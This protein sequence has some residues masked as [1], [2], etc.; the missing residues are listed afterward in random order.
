MFRKVSATLVALSLVLAACT[1][2]VVLQVTSYA[3]L[4]GATDVSVETVVTATFS[5]AIDEDTVEGSF[6]LTTVA[7]AIDGVLT[8]DAATRTAT[9]APDAPLAY[10]TLHTVT[11]SGSVATTGGVTLGGD[12]G[13]TFTTEAEPVE[14]A[15]GGVDVTPATADLLVGATV[16]LTATPSG[17]V[18]TPDLGVTWSSD[19]ETVATV[20]DAGLVTAQ[21]EGT[22][23]ITA[24]SDFDPSVSDSATIT[25]S[26]VPSVVSVSVT[27]T[28]PTVVVGGTVQLSADVVTVGGAADGVT[29]SSDDE[30]IAT[31]DDAGLV[32]AQGE[33]TAVITATS[34]FDASVSGTA[35]VEV[36]PFSIGGYTIDG[37][38]AP[39]AVDATAQLTATPV[40]VVGS[41]DTSVTWESDDDAVATIDAAG[42]VTAVAPGTATMTATSVFDPAV[43]A[44]FEIEVATPL[45][46]VGIPDTGIV[47]GYI[48][49]VDAGTA[50]DPALPAPFTGGVAPYTFAVVTPADSPFAL[51][52]VPDGMTIDP[53]T[54]ELS[55]TPT[56]ARY[57]NFAVEATDAI[58]Q[59]AVAYGEVEVFLVLQ[60]ASATYVYDNTLA[61]ATIV[62]STDVTVVGADPINN[63]TFTLGLVSTTPPGGVLDD[64]SIDTNTGAITYDVTGDPYVWTIEVTVL[65]EVAGGSATFE[66]T[67]EPLVP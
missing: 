16:Q 27:P 65:D 37:P 5:V 58:G 44:T 45:E 64:W 1:T 3:P 36:L 19:D 24:T 42:E 10:A 29:W 8:Y 59:T 32:T 21:G 2:P 33:G 55:G 51:Q 56:L 4:D 15:I 35:E 23:V 48:A 49:D 31:V 11:V 67:F 43:T 39:L 7:G 28:S 61:P 26:P 54:G 9:F 34:D 53:S 52:G 20:D 14:D 63:L 57:Y 50:L 41:P 62:P 46:A 38:E 6:A 60:Y 18:G 25:V 22:A 17:V 40:D 47:V 66:V 12:V 30:A 13:W